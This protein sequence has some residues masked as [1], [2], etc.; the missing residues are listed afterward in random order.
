MLARP[1]T[2]ICLWPNRGGI[3]PNRKTK[4]TS[5]I[6]VETFSLPK[7]PPSPSSENP[8]LSGAVCCTRTQAW[9]V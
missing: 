1:K 9:L 8:H 4:L 3:E 2:M 6:W 5:N 7:S